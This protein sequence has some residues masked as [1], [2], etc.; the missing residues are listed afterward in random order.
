MVAYQDINNK[1][2]KI[3]EPQNGFFPLYL[4]TKGVVVGALATYGKDKRKTYETMRHD[5]LK[6]QRGL[7]VGPAKT[8]M[9]KVMNPLCG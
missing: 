8:P 2:I 1:V 4:Q 7:V 9:V 6:T 5:I 3:T